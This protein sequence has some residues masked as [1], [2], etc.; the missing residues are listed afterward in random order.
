LR[1]VDVS[2]EIIVLDDSGNG[3]A[4]DIC[5][6]HIS[7]GNVKY[8][9]NERT[10]GVAVS[11][12]RGLENARGSFVA[13]LNDDDFWTPNFLA[14]LVTP[15]L[16]DDKCVLSFCDH[17]VVDRRGSIDE[18][19][20]DI[21]SSH[22][23]RASLLEGRVSDPAEL[24]LR[25]NGVPLAMG[26]LFRK[27][28]L[29]AAMLTADVSGA[30][31]FWISCLLASTGRRFYFVKERLTFYRV[32][33]SMETSRRGPDKTDNQVAIFSRLIDGN[34]FPSWHNFLVKKLSSAMLS[35]GRHRLEFAQIREARALF[36]RSFL[37]SPN[38]KAIGGLFICLSPKTLRN[39]ILKQL[40]RKREFSK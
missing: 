19:L 30:Y 17:W 15:L 22:Y 28:A 18:V 23:T 27:D 20:S 9:A 29:P 11:L 36:I 32:H 35:S 37:T 14:K 39:K 4:R 16:S 10:T 5:A 31:D 12:R 8:L 6:T 38:G 7:K 21:T 26:A 25:F 33:S 34:Y 1:Q 13:V 24:V 3:C 2:F 40:T